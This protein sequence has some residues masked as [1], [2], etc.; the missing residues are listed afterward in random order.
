MSHRWGRRQEKHLSV[1]R[2]LYTRN[3][4]SLGQRYLL[5]SSDMHQMLLNILHTTVSVIHYKV[6]FSFSQSLLFSY[7]KILLTLLQ[8]ERKH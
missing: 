1:R 4:L 6:V 7:R 3:S 5:S 2:A 8:A